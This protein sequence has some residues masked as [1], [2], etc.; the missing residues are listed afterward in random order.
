[1]AGWGGWGG[2]GC[3]GVGVLVGGV[4][5]LLF[6]LVFFALFGW[7][8]VGVQLAR[9]TGADAL[10]VHP[11]ISISHLMPHSGMACAKGKAP[12]KKRSTFSLSGR[13]EGIGHFRS[14]AVRN[15]KGGA[16]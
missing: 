11:S 5:W 16:L 6:G 7:G 12:K 4:R 13:S 3:G 8:L 15:L 2:F 14:I 10:P 1:M 9:G